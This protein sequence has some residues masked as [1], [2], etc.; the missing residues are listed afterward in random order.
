MRQI[1]NFI[2]LVAGL[3]CLSAVYASPGDNIFLITKFVN[4]STDSFTMGLQAGNTGIPQE[5]TVANIPNGT[6]ATS[7]MI[8]TVIIRQ[9]TP[10]IFNLEYSG[11][12]PVADDDC[13]I[14]VP[15]KGFTTAVTISTDRLS[16]V[17]TPI[18]ISY[19][20]GLYTVFYDG[21]TNIVSCDF[22]SLSTLKL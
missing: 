12:Y 20:H 5:P 3:L 13:T 19:I 14:T 10:L 22:S 2:L 1:N 7:I 4:N 6:R 8:P 17:V 11:L 9:D 16:I 21:T 18:S 15:T